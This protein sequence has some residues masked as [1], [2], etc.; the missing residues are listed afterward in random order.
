MTC[1]LCGAEPRFIIMGGDHPIGATYC[2]RCL[3]RL[4]GVVHA[5]ELAL[6]SGPACDFCTQPTP[7]GWTMT[8]REVAAMVE[9]AEDGST[10]VHDLGTTWCVCGGCKPYVESILQ[11]DDDTSG[12]E[13]L[14]QRVVS[15]HPQLD[16]DDRMMVGLLWAV[17]FS[18]AVWPL[19]EGVPT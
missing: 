1:V 14:W 19:I 12:L 3:A 9:V 16:N 5:Q 18:H 15:L 17:V 2:E 4:G 10:M 8:T 7:T 11:S 13:L 6:A